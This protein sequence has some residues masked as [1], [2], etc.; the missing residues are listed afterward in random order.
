MTNSI[1]NKLN[2]RQRQAVETT[3]GPVLIIAGAG[4][5]KT[6]ALTHR[7][8]YLI[9]TKKAQPHNILA[10]TFTNKAAGEMKDRVTKLLQGSRVVPTIGTFHSVCA[11]ILRHEIEHLGYKRSFT[12]YDNND[13]L[14]AVKRAMQELHIDTKENHPRAVLEMISSAKNE[15]ITAKEFESRTQ[16]PIEEMVAR[17]YY[18]YQKTLKDS[19]AL[20]FDDLLMV[21]VQL[22]QKYPE[23]LEKYRRQWQYIL[24][25][26]YQDT[27]NAQYVFVNLLAQKHK[28]LCVVGDD[29]QS[30]YSWRGADIRNILEFEKD[31]SDA[32]VIMLEQNYRST[33][34]ILDAAQEVIA[35]NVSKKEKKLW[36][37]KKGGQPVRIYTAGDERDE[38]RFALEKIQNLKN[39]GRKYRDTVILY[40]TNAQSRVFEEALM[41]AAIPY[42]IVG[43]QKFYERKEIKDILAYLRLVASFTDIVSWRRVVNEPSRGVG[44]KTLAAVDALVT[45]HGLEKAIAEF[46]R[47]VDKSK[48]NIDELAAGGISGKSFQRLGKAKDGILELKNIVVDSRQYLEKHTV[49]ELIDFVAQRSSYKEYILDG[50]EEGEMRWENIQELKSVASKYNDSRGLESLEKFLEEVALVQDVD[51]LN[52]NEDTVT[53]MTLHSAKGLEFPIVFIAGLEEGLFPHGRSYLDP[54]QMEEERRLCYVGMTRAQQELWLM[55]AT[56]RK[57]FG[58]IQFNEPSQFL[59]LNKVERTTSSLA[60]DGEYTFDETEV[61]ID[62]TNKAS[63]KEGGRP[64][65]S[66]AGGGAKA[67]ILDM[68]MGEDLS[69]EA[70]E[71]SLAQTDDDVEYEEIDDD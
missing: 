36:T 12:I 43:A 60:G 54:A 71:T 50:S 15:L 62:Q 67:G 41:Q 34:N 20:D 66:P 19:N 29:W 1:L 9:A 35:K 38:A 17:I 24:V 25:D 39:K 42:T 59:Q 65:R 44:E 70:E 33:S 7:I 55:H 16:S 32:K 18:R 52:E 64:R 63:K 30:I 57:L 46:A 58:S 49:A 40:R 47:A 37:D 68:I 48:D 26:E 28:N 2:D 45:K 10:V 31:Y 3:D 69:A 51:N 23:I 56:S 6:K 13:Q 27:N 14:A 5:G 53:L 4:S 21:T 61:E 22:F 11:R 8:A